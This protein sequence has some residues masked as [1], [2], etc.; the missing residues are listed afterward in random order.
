MQEYTDA[1]IKISSFGVNRFT[2]DEKAAR[3]VF[4]FAKAAG[5]SAIS[6]DLA[7]G[8]LAVAEK[9]CEE[10]GK[11]IAI[12][13]HGRKHELGSVRALESLF[14]KSS[15]NIGLCLDTAWMLDSGEDPVAIAEKFKDRLYGLHLKDFI[16]TVRDIWK[17]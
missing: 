3:Q 12:H 14:S 11:K 7:E 1:G 10:Y 6:A 2:G 8:G 16:L 13:N 5:F 4:D 17:M 15:P 9:L